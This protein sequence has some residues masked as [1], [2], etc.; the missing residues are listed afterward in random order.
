MNFFDKAFNKAPSGA[1]NSSP[2]TLGMMAGMGDERFARA[3]A[4]PRMRTARRIAFAA[5]ILLLCAG[6]VSV[7]AAYEAFHGEAPFLEWLFVSGGVPAGVGY[8][9]SLSAAGAYCIW[10]AWLRDGTFP[11]L[12]A[13]GMPAAFLVSLIMAGPA[14]D[15]AGL[16]LGNTVAMRAGCLASCLGITM[17]LQK[18]LFGKQIKS[19]GD[20]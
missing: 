15:P 18:V 9:L 4:S 3:K 7:A 12:M 13:L 8:C 10:A 14:A 17:I 5:G 20:K 11:V 2:E 1:G 16:A 6:P 19:E